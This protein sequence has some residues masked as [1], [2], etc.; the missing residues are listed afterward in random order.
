AAPGERMLWVDGDYDRLPGDEQ[1]LRIGRG[2]VVAAQT[3]QR[4]VELACGQGREQGVGLVLDQPQLDPWVVSVE[5]A[6]QAEEAP[7]REGLDEA[8]R[9]APGDQAAERRHRLA[10][11]LGA[12]EHRPRVR[13]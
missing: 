2:A 1:G 3:D 4:G 5:R 10:G 13:Q 11:A 7:I 9:E 12:G 6:Q 8:E